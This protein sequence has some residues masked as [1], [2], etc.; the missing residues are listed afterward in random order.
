MARG[1]ETEIRAYDGE[2]ESLTSAT[3]AGHRHPG[4]QS[5]TGSVSPGPDPSMARC[6]RRHWPRRGT[7]PPSPPPTSTSD[8]PHPT[9]WPPSPSTCGTTGWARCPPPTRS[10]WPWASKPPARAAD[11]RIRQVDHADYGDGSV[12]VALVST[13]GIRAS[14]RKTSSYLSVGVIA[15]EGD[16]SQTGERLQ[17]RTGASTASTRTRP[18]ATRSPGRY[19]CSGPPRVPPSARPWS[20]TAGWPPRSCRW[21]P[22]PFPARP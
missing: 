12:E 1:D 19:A 16:A 3:S 6:P 14:S 2:V 8:W 13:T 15:G 18:S 21:S 4:G 9:G 5:T 10:S 17:R 22:R 20:S 7:T 11:P